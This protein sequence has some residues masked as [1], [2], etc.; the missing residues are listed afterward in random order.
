MPPDELVRIL[1]ALPPLLGLLEG[2]DPSIELYPDTASPSLANIRTPNGKWQVR[3]GVALERYIGGSG[4][5]RLLY[6]LYEA[7]GN[8]VRLAAQ[9]TGA[10]ATL[11]KLL[12]G[13]DTAFIAATGGT[14][15]GGTS[16]PYFQGVTLNDIFYFTDRAGNLR[17]FQ[18]VPSSGNQVRDVQLPVKPTAAPG[19]KARTF[20]CLD[21]F[22]GAAPFGWTVADSAKFDIE[23]GTA[24]L[25]SPI[26][27]VV[28]LLNTKTNPKNSPISKHVTAEAVPSNTIAFWMYASNTPSHVVFQY[29][30]VTANDFT[31]ILNPPT[32]SQW[33]PVFVE[34]GPMGTLNFKQFLVTENGGAADIYVSKL[35]LPGRLQGSYR[36]VYT[37]Y[38]STL[39]R[40]SEPSDVSNS[41][42][43]MDFS[44]VGTDFAPATAAAFQKSAAL[45]FTSD[46][47]TDSTTT[48]IRIYRNG[49][50]P[51]LTKDQ[52]GLDVWLRVGEIFDQSTTASGA[53]NTAGSTTFTVASATNIAVGDWLV[54]EKGTVS[55]EE[56]VRVTSIAGAPA[57]TISQPLLYAHA[58][59]VAVQIA[60]VDNV[61]NEQIDVTARI[62]LERDDPPAASRYVARSPDGRLWLFNVTGKPTGVAVSNRSTP[63]RPT[64]YEVFPDGVDP[65]TRQNPLQ[66]WRFEIGGDSTDESITWGGLFHDGM[67]AFTRRRL[68]SINAYAQ[69]DWG[70]SAIQPVLEAGCIAGDTVQILNGWLYWVAPGPQV[71]RWSGRGAPEIL[72]HLKVNERLSTAAG[73][74]LDVWFATSYAVQ[75]GRYYRLVYDPA[76]VA[77][78]ASTPTAVLDFLTDAGPEGAWEPLSYGHTWRAADVRRG[79]GDAL[80]L[81]MADSIGGIYQMESGSTDAGT[82]ITASWS[83]KKLP[84]GAVSL[85]HDVYLRLDAVT[86]SASVVISVGGSEYGDRSRTYSVSYAGSGDRDIKIRVHRDMIGRW[87]QV[88]VSGA[89]SNR[90]AIRDV[91]VV[92]VPIRG[93]HVSD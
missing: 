1:P 89:Y 12:V 5:V 66:G 52:T 16:Q 85:V 77:G 9:G 72:S 10:S 27:G 87:C 26:G 57:L 62:D 19:V 13:T 20:E 4:D 21:Q 83:S 78:V 67:F 55:K 36:W 60:F 81:F 82:A 23:V 40:E 14:G 61:A 34:I 6:T 24:T 93:G 15:L 37:H 50:V 76:P 69:T 75:E 65:L 92:F 91:R 38:D 35:M 39:L 44:A 22:T 25:E 86:D 42:S 33:Y 47:G 84:M 18:R 63:D 32:R 48:K 58:N 88:S 53:G 56:Y 31:E 73:S 28:A 90:P 59:G 7:A 17:K 11:F 30:Q 49:G 79:A 64:D 41:G 70:P 68:Y 43:P 71:M 29:G 2:L 80:E 51:S 74:N 54:I 46:S 8:R 3:K 45:T